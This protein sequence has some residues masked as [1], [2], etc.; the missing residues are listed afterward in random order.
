M[1]HP[2]HSFQRVLYAHLKAV[3]RRKPFPPAIEAA[4][5]KILRCGE[6]EHRSLWENVV[7]SRHRLGMKGFR[8]VGFHE[9]NKTREPSTELALPKKSMRKATIPTNTYGD[10]ADFG[11]ACAFLCSDQAKF[12]V[13]QNLLLDGGAINATL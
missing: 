2:E 10:P 3:D 12:I 6:H 7:G 4:L 8:L 5:L 1:K 11:A 9:K 13:G